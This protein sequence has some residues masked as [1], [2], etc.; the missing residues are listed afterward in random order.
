MGDL[1]K[2]LLVLAMALMVVVMLIEV[3]SS[4]LI[5]APTTRDVAGQTP[6][7][8]QQ[9]LADADPGQLEA[10]SRQDSPGLA[11]PAM[12]LLD[13]VVLFSVALIAGALIVP[14]GV[15]GRVQGCVTFVFA[16]LLLLGAIVTILTTLAL[17][18]LMLSL[19][20]SVP[21]GTIAY[22]AIYGFFPRGAASNVL[23]L[24]LLLKVAAGG[25]L[26]LAHQRFLQNLGLLL[27]VATSLLGNVVVSFL[28]ALVPGFLVSI[29]DGVAA[30]VVALL[31]AIWA[32]LLLIGAI[33]GILRA[34]RRH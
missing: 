20:L 7:E 25:C 30:I 16:L 12:A 31:A 29:T 21:F 23:G 33:P 2:P 22:L 26:L 19:L 3:G 9:A 1:R 11:I 27:V 14:A 13:T 4:A 17:V 15:Q 34:V 5:K 28:H 18:I 8:A 10:L 6:P 32:L 24:L